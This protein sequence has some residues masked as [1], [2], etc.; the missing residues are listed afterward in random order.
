MQEKTALGESFSV[1]ENVFSVLKNTDGMF[2]R[3]GVAG[4]H[5]SAPGST[6]PLK[7]R[8][9]SELMA[10]H[11][12]EKRP[13]R[14]ACTLFQ[15]KTGATPPAREVALHQVLHGEA[16]SLYSQ[17]AAVADASPSAADACGTR[18][19]AYRQGQGR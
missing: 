4:E 18:S 10:N 12:T 3:D 16:N 13:P 5:V 17:G 7:K 11:G 6:R 14:G 2:S 1:E 15:R 8:T 9:G 19:I